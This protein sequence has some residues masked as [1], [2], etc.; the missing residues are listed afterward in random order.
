MRLALQ[1]AVPQAFGLSSDSA[2][3]RFL[4]D[5][6]G[7]R[8]AHKRAALRRAELAL[9]AQL[10][11]SGSMLAISGSPQSASSLRALSVDKGPQESVRIAPLSQA[12][13]LPPPVR[14]ERRR[15]LSVKPWLLGAAAACAAMALLSVWRSGA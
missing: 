15:A 12:P 7:E 10:K 11:E 4:A 13:T 1:A 8:P 2:L 9:D 3:N 6:V 14:S 5:L